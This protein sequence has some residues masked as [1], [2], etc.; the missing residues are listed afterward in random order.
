MTTSF[1]RPFRLLVP[2]LFR[3]GLV[4][5][6]IG[7]S[8]AGTHPHFLPRPPALDF[9]RHWEAAEGQRRAH[10]SPACGGAT[11]TSP[12]CNTWASPCR[13]TRTHSVVVAFIVLSCQVALTTGTITKYIYRG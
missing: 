11:V 13:V 12:A 7:Q 4:L 10:S 8:L 5:Y 9:Q 2:T 1:A 3:L 6:L